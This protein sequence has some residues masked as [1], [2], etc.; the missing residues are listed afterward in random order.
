MGKCST[1]NSFRR[2]KKI[3]FFLDF[4]DLFSINKTKTSMENQY[5]FDKSI[6]RFRKL[7]IGDLVKWKVGD[8]IRKG[9]FKQITDN[10]AEVITTFVESHPINIKCFV[11]LNLIEIDS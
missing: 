1:E 8:K 11:P 7:E 9:I 5:Y 6:S 10:S 2:S 4:I 3:I